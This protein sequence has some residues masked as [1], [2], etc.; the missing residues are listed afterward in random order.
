[1]VGLGDL[2]GGIFFSEA[3]GV[4]A[5]G[6][7]VVGWSLA[8]ES[9]FEAFLWTS[10]GGMV[11][12]SDL[13]G[14][15]FE[16]RANDVSADGSVVVGQGLSA[17]GIEAFIWDATNGIQNLQTVLEG[18]LGVALTG[19]TLTDAVGISADGTT[20]VGVGNNPS[21]DLEAF[22]AVITP[23]NLCLGD[24]TGDGNVNVTDL[25]DLLA[26][27]GP[28]PGH[29]ADINND[30]DVNVNDLLSLLGAWGVCP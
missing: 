6:S 12:L 28:N 30:G 27:W 19:W 14:G 25:L 2:T 10:G 9:V 4:S 22:V 16:S 23:L 17:L 1:M 13:P 29:P 7:T 21:G 5:D 15:L 8:T 24:I 3:F 26:A 11:G 18:Q 20:I